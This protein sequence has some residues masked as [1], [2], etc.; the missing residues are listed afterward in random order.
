MGR[1]NY[2]VAVVAVIVLGMVEV[3]AAALPAYASEE[4]PPAPPPIEEPVEDPPGDEGTPPDDTRTPPNPVER[5]DVEKDLVFPVVGS[6]YYYAGFGACRDNCTR[7]HHGIDIMSYNWKGLPVVAAHSGTVTKV[8]YDQG[9]AGCSVRIKGTDRWE[10]RYYH[11]NND[12]PGTDEIGQPCPAAGI[13]VGTKVQAGQLIGYVGDS[14]NAETT[15]PHVHFELRTPN[16]H[17]VD[18]YRSL[19]K[20]E[21]VTY[22]W[23]PTDFAETALAITEHYKPDPSTTTVVMTTDE[24]PAIFASESDSMFLNAPILAVDPANPDPALDEIGRLNSKAIV[25]MSDADVRWLRDLLLDISP[26]V[27]QI[28]IPSFETRHPPMIPDAVDVPTMAPNP[29]DVFATVI[30]GRVDK[31]WRSRQEAFADF[32]V[33]HRSV[34]IVDDQYGK[35]Y[36]GHRSSASPGR[37]ADRKLLWWATGDGW[38]GTESMEDVPHRGY[39]YV[40]ERLATPWTLAFLGS[41]AET[42]QMPRWRS[43]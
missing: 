33:D 41:L 38:V 37:Y 25:I 17:P 12:L 36:I 35:R 9:N 23:L 4:P 8:T 10:T 1:T 32:T 42:P 43:R 14:G 31:I 11:L 15:P 2:A 5:I 6:T 22:E 21:R 7:E 16:G 30:A 40:T 24:A 26:I 29:R 27:E 20:A 19:R 13:E 39:A 18:P 28:P 3:G 34:V